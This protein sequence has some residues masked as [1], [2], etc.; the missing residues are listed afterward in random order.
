MASTSKK[1]K[2]NETYQQYGFTKFSQ[3]GLDAAQ[4]IH[5]STVLANCSLKPAKLS[6]HQ[7]NLHPNIELTEED[8]E[9]KRKRFDKQ[10]T[11][12]TYGF[13]PESKPMVQASF[14]VALKIAERKKAHTIGEE[15]IKPCAEIMVRNVLG[16]KAKRE[17]SKISL[18]NN[19]VRRRIDDMAADVCNQVCQEI[20]ASEFRASLQLDESTD[21]ANQSQL[22]AFVR[23]EKEKK[24]KEEFLFCE[25]LTT[26]TT[27]EEVKKLVDYFFEKN[28]LSWMQFQ[29][30]CTDGAPAMIGVRTGFVTLVKSKW[31]HIS[32]SHCSLH[33]YAL[34]SKTMPPELM[35][36][37]DSV[38][39]SI[40]FI[41]GR[42]KNHRLF[43]MMAQEMGSTH[44]SLLYHTQVRW[45]SRGKCL[46]R[47]FEMHTEVEIFLREME[48]RGD[49]RHE[50]YKNPE[51][52]MKLAYLAD[53][54]GTL[55]EVN[56]TLQGREASVSDVK[57]KLAG[58]GARIALWI[59]RL[60][61]GNV[62]AFPLLD[63]F[64]LDKQLDLPDD[65][66]ESIAAH[67]E[68]L[69]SEFKAYFDGVEPAYYPWYKDPFGAVVDDEM[70]EAEELLMLRESAV[71]K[72]EFRKLSLSEFWLQQQ[73]TYPR[74]CN[75]AAQMFLPF[76][77]TYLCEAGFSVM[78]DLKPKKRNRLEMSSDMRL[79]CSETKPNILKLVADCKEQ[80][81]H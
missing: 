81:S 79:A 54:F 37:L 63:A 21:I 30:I 62:A 66:K 75:K 2:W 18:S 20:R 73:D 4:C 44:T 8:L 1:R 55:N 3:D 33:R 42:A 27:A 46:A 71:A 12:P 74:L 15:L 7:S 50:N 57:D 25:L 48:T 45:L 11:L 52:L 35:S 24:V 14:E 39:S 80:V 26:T 32:N 38:I 23:Y 78:F 41:R 34:A 76:P 31:P 60:H 58:L 72:A 47:V 28:G 40:N 22:I 9:A 29:H 64:L 10:G 56:V 53:I 6:H 65:L 36:V 77:T 68:R 17:I 5:C 61:R 59:R 69:T 49:H 16:D 70:E 43:G 51:F 19:T 13:Q 67:L